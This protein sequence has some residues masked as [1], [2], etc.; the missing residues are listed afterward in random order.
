MST[1]RIQ[2]R[3]C[4][5]SAEPYEVTLVYDKKQIIALC[6]CPAGE[7]FVACKHWKYVFTGEEQDYLNSLSDNQ[8]A[9]IQGWLNGSEL[10]QAW[11]AVK[12]TE[13]EMANLKK[14]LE[15]AKKKFSRVSSGRT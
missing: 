4:G 6:N 12:D 3:V 9:E 2:F 11:L 15:A 10:E 14:R 13:R 8:I 5:S 7:K 1:R